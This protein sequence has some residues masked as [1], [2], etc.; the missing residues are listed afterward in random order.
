M[1]SQGQNRGQAFLIVVI[2][3]TDQGPGKG[4]VGF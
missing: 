1:I 4:S 2:E 3:N